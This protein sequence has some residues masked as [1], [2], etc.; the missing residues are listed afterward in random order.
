MKGHGSSTVKKGLVP[1]DREDAIYPWMEPQT[2][3]CSISDDD[4]RPG[5]SGTGKES[6]Q[7]LVELLKGCVSKH[8]HQLLHKT[9]NSSVSLYTGLWPLWDRLDKEDSSPG[10][11]RNV[12]G[13][14][15]APGTIKWL[16]ESREV[17]RQPNNQ[18][19]CKSV[20]GTTRCLLHAFQDE[21][22]RD[23]EPWGSHHWTILCPYAEN[24]H[25]AFLS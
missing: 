17:T 22:T 16:A 6:L 20:C 15:P 12:V 11:L 9:A 1:T 4:F 7:C 10:N 18:N 5:G 8:S 25:H 23:D 19:W 2:L 21:N 14:L 3:G 24:N 13:W